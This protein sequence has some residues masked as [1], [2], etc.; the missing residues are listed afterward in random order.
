VVAEPEGLIPL[1][2]PPLDM[3]LS[4]FHPFHT[5]NSYFPKIIFMPS[6]KILGLASGHFPI[7]FPTTIL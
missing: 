3:I 6:Y 1:S 4:Q 2:K 5:L 7:G